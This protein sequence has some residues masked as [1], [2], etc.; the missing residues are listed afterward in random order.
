MTGSTAYRLNHEEIVKAFE[1]GIYFAELLAPKEI[2][3]D[4]T[5]HVSAIRLERQSLDETGR[6]QPT[7]EETTLPARA[8]L[9]A[10]GTQPNTV[11][12]REH[13]G[14]AELDCKY[15]QAVDEAGAKVTPEWTAKPDPAQVL[16]NPRDDGR[17][18]SF[19]GDLHPSF[20]GN[21]VKAMA[22]ARQ[23]YPVVERALAK[24]PPSVGDPA[25]L[26]E[27]LNSGLRARV[28]AVK[29]L[30]SNVVQVTVRAPMA[31]RAF[32]PGQFFR[33]QNYEANAQ[34]VD[35][36][37][38]AMEGVALTGAIVD[39]DEGLV[40]VISLDMGGSTT[41]LSL[42]Q[43]GEPV[44]LMGP[45][46]VPTKTRAGDTALLCGGGLGNAVLMTINKGFHDAGARVLYFAAYKGVE[47][48]F[49]I[50]RIMKNADVVVWCCDEA[51]GFEPSRPQDKAFVGN[52]VQAME[53]Y[54]KGE[55]GKVSIP[56]SEC[57]HVIAIGSDRMMEAVQQAR[58]GVLK[59]YL[60]P[61]HEAIA[62]INS[63]MQCMMK[64]ICGQCLQKHKKR[65]TGEESVVY[66]CFCQDQPMDEVVFE[67]LRERLA[68]NAVH[69]K[70]TRK[71]IAR[72]L[73]Q[74]EGKVAR[75]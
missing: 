74:L 65:D 2:L 11:L 26:M 67:A 42:L 5:Q 41:L 49:H 44:I 4:D 14:F 48:R 21:V 72:S 63:P 71:W 38:L 19:F 45:T 60:L 8:V 56:L 16:M 28:H 10:A 52:I 51:P 58:H 29:R 39:A 55:L 30:T 35:D 46:G 22:S 43:P 54:G 40:S 9:I 50:E 7:G 12:S 20:A 70:L 32:K 61:G 47:D 34:R 53:A 57:N 73:R 18:M 59:P 36:T 69:E 33:I 62:S 75:V 13:P 25:E 66:S 68:Q 24:R 37:V 23:G 3:V 64:E 17:C 27:S 15:F 31:A 1:Q 6:P